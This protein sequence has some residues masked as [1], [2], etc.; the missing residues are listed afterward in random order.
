MNRYQRFALVLGVVMVFTLAKQD[1]FGLAQ[2]NRDT[3]RGLEGFPVL[4]ARLGAEIEKDGLTKE[5]LQTDTEQRLRMAG[6]KVFSLEE[7]IREKGSPYF[8]L[9]VHVDKLQSGCYS[10]NI[11]TELIK[12]AFPRWETTWTQ[13]ELMGLSC[14]LSDIRQ[15]AQD[16]VDEFINEYLAA[17]QKQTAKTGP[18]V[19][20]DPH[21]SHFTRLRQDGPCGSAGSFTP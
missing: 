15:Q 1:S 4:V 6:I 13:L 2:D 11:S 21:F 9:H 16:M 12:E 3:L 19:T 10:F 17:N 8:Y 18:T 14:N 7:A 5:Q 20:L